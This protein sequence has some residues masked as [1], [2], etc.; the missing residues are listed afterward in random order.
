MHLLTRE[1]F[2]LYFRKLTPGG[3]LAVHISN[4]AMDFSGVIGRIAADLGYVAYAKSD[5]D[6]AADDRDMRTPSVAVVVAR[7]AVDLGRLTEPGGDWR[8][9]Q[10]DDAPLWT[11]DYSTILT[12]IL[13]KFRR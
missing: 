3:L 12:A 6:V 2:E 9:L 4:N 13:A 5:L 8:R 10:A 1:A 11:D 7:A